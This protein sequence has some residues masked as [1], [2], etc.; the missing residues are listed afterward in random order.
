MKS[1]TSLFVIARN[2]AVRAGFMVMAA[3]ATF[4]AGHPSDLLGGTPDV[5]SV[6]NAL[7]IPLS[8]AG[9]DA[10]RVRLA[11]HTLP[12]LVGAK[13]TVA[14]T[15][16]LTLTLVLKHDDEAGFQRYLHDVYDPGSPQFRHFLGPAQIA[17]SFGPSQ[18]AYE[19][20][21]AYLLA[22][23]FKQVETSS[24]RMTLTVRSRR[25]DVESAFA[26]HIDD[27]AGPDGTFFAN[28]A[29][30]TLP[31]AIAAHVQA[32]IGLSDFARPRPLTVKGPPQYYV[33]PMGVDPA[34]CDLYGPLCAIYAGA[35]ATGEFL[36]DLEGEGKGIRDY[37]KSYNGY[38]KNVQDYYKACLDNN[39]PD[40]ATDGNAI[41][42][43][44]VP[45][46]QVDGSGQTIGLVEFDQY[47]TSD[48]ADYLDLVGAPADE[49][50]HL[51]EVY[52]GAGASFG[53]SESEVVLDIDVAMSLAPNANIVVYSAGFAAGSSY[54]QIFNRMISDGVTVISNSWAYCE[55]QTTQADA[56]SIDAILQSAAAAGISVF[57]GSGDTGSVCLDG[58]PNTIAVP[59]D[60]PNLTAVGGT[61]LAAGAGG[62][63]QGETWWDGS[64]QTPQ[65]GQGGFGVSRFFARPSYQDGFTT[66]TMRSVPDVS[67]EADPES[68]LIICQADAGGCPTGF[69]YGGTSMAT[70]MWAAF[71]AL[72]NQAHGSNLGLVNPSLYPLA[73]S[74]AFHGAASM[75]TNFAHVGL[76]SP[77]LSA[78]N[79][80]LSGQTAGTPSADVSEVLA[81]APPVQPF[82]D[83]LGV[84]ADGTSPGVIIVTLRDADGNT[85]ADKTVTLAQSA[86]GHATITPSSATSGSDGVVTFKATDLTSE[87]LTF[88]ATD[89]TDG[90]TLTFAQNLPFIAPPSSSGGIV[91]FPTSQTADGSSTSMVTVTLHD[92]LGRPSPG[93]L[94]ELAQ[95]GNSLILGDNP[96]LTDSNGEAA[97]D[98]T[99]Q[100][101]ETVAYTA[102]DTTDGD[103]PVPGSASVDF[104]DG[105]GCG[106]MAPPVA[107]PGYAI[108]LYASGFTLQNG[109]SFG[110][111]TVSGCVGVGGIAFD[112]AGDLFASDYVTGNVYDI[113]PGGGVV[114][115]GN[116]ITGTPIGPSLGALTFGNDGN[117]YGVRVAT[118]GDFTTG[119]VL[120]INTATGIATPVSS[121]LPCPFNVATDPLSGDLFVSDG[122]FGNG[123]DNPSI[124]RVVNPGGGSPSTSVYAQ[125]LA[126]P[127][128]GL[129]FADDGTLYVVY[130]YNSVV[131]EVDQISGTNQ[132]QPPTVQSTG[133]GS[134]FAV[135]ALGTAPG[136]GAQALVVG[137]SRVGGVPESVAVFD[138]TVNPP[139]FSGAMLEETGAGSMRVVGPDGCFYLNANVGVYR[140]SNADGTCPTT[141]QLAPNPSLLVD[142]FSEPPIAAQGTAQNFAISFPHTMVPVGTPVT[143]VV[144]GANSLQEAVFMGFGSSAFFSYVGRNVGEDTVVAFATIDGATVISNQVPV[145][146][147][148]GR[149]STFLT[150]NGSATAGP[151][152]GTASAT[153]TLLDLSVDPAVPVPGET[154]GFA[155]GTSSCNATTDSNGVATCALALGAP[156]VLT[157]TASFA[158]DATFLSANDTL[159]FHV[160]DDTIFANGF[161][162]P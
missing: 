125:T 107:A 27:Y 61:S 3:T 150:L 127:N 119:A 157:L 122:C 146:W 32:I 81:T 72:L 109:V 4:C 11:G 5:R 23:N 84:P 115:P 47:Q 48:I 31:A 134:T 129:S 30:P 85:V 29:D 111:I 69:F 20:V 71:T 25:A 145:G 21:A 56:A 74:A 153:A 55:D 144:S 113:P 75:N 51:S 147:T 93:K 6:R 7:S 114:G 128:G 142:P 156:G 112:E 22:R 66:S 76:G 135:T 86:G 9:T 105:N 39:F 87:E 54:Q 161:E 43:G 1:T 91:A 12:G 77:N 95:S 102:V 82:D 57:S 130:A 40:R 34:R 97:F 42:G 58:S 116:I 49:I 89:I 8:A 160:L 154:I 15:A 159:A 96:G 138:T 108:S 18:Q 19:E 59:A 117:L 88:T 2:L 14:H 141:A 120:K 140:L 63:R 98:V 70:P 100:V 148:S 78:L 139:V 65:T 68:G 83:N 62:V 67:A 104:A 46:L 35:R 33:C 99:D 24:N 137:A 136:G 110:G 90:V 162:A 44:A 133:V 36:Q 17:D 26:V 16:S 121:N 126:S 79:L 53:G 158:G 132:A 123:S 92:A 41:T 10:E 149:H 124:W 73:S 151:S 155:L 50:N 118:T 64:A 101:T 13:T 38:N 106:S 60:S 152:G 45:W 103:L 37:V 131:A 80:L 28:D 52:V 94:V 143:V